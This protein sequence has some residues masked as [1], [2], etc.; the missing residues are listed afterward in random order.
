MDKMMWF[1]YGFFSA[2]GIIVLGIVG[3]GVSLLYRIISF[4]PLGLMVISGFLVFFGI[5]F[6]I[7]KPNK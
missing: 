4:A 3:W 6:W 5:V 1:F 2:I 7:L